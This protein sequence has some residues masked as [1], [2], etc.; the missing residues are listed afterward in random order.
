MR[1]RGLPWLGSVV[2]L[3]LI[4]LYAT[5]I[6]PR[7]ESA[8]PIY[9]AIIW[10]YHQPWYYSP[11]ESY[12]VLPWVRM[13]GVGNYYKMGYI[14]SKYPDVKVTFTFS[15]SLLVQLL[16]YLKG[17]M[18]SY[19]IL[20][21]KAANGTQLSAEDVYNMIKIPGGF[22]DI[23]WNRIVNV[24]PR[25]SQLRSAAQNA[26]ATCSAQPLSEEEFVKCVANAFTFGNYTSQSVI[27]LA[28]LFNLFWIDPQVAREQYPRVYELMQRALNSSYP[29]FT[30]DDLRYVLEVQRDIL[31]K[32]IPLYRDLAAKGQAE[33][34]PVP[35]SHPL[36]PI[37]VDFGWTDDLGVQVARSLEL[38]KEH[39]NYTPRGVWPAEQAVNDQVLEA[40][41]GAGLE[42]AVTDQ[43]LLQATGVNAQDINNL[44][45]PW[46]ANYS[47]RAFYVFFRNTDLSNAISFQ[48]SGMPTSSA[49]DDL[50]SRIRAMAASARGPRL[51]VIALDGENPWENYV[52]FGD[53]FLNAL[54]QRLEE[55]QRQG[56]VFTIT[57]SEFLEKFP[58]EAKQLQPKLYEYL[59][60]AGK[61]ISNIPLDSWGDGY[62]ELPRRTVRAYMPEGSWASG[63]IQ[64]WI[65]SRQDNVAWMWMAKARQDVLKALG[66]SSLTEA[67]RLNPTAVE[68]LLRA[69]ASDWWYWYG[70]EMGSPRTFD[71]IFKAFLRQAY[72]AAGLTPPD[73][74]SATFY[75]D[76]QPIGWMNSAVPMPVEQM[77]APD[78]LESLVAQGR[79]LK[80]PVGPSPVTYAYVAVS[81]SSAYFYFLVAP[82]SQGITLAIY[83]ASPKTDLSPYH[84]GYNVFPP[85]YTADLGIALV[86]QVLL[87]FGAQAAD[88][89]VALGNGEWRHVGSA[90]ASNY[91][92]P[93]GTLA[94]VEVPWSLLNFSGGNRV[95]F[96]LAV[97]VN[98]TL[99]ES[100]TKLGN[101]WLV[102]VPMGVAGGRVIFDMKDP[103][104]DDDG[105]GGYQYPK[106]PVFVKGVFDMTEFKVLDAGDRLVFYTY[107]VTLG[108]NPWGGPNGW[109]MQ[110]VHIY[111]HTTLPGGNTTT[112]GLNV[113]VDPA[114]AWHFA[115]LLAPGWG[116]DPVPGGQKSALYYSNGTVIV[117]DTNGFRVYADQASNA[118][119]AEVPKALLP[120]VADVDKWIF[121][122]AVT[123]YDGFSPTKVRAFGIEA[124]QWVCGAPKYA[125]AILKGVL[126]YVLDVLAPTAEDQYAMLNSFDA[127]AGKLAVIRGYGPS[128]LQAT[129]PTTTTPVTTSPPAVTTTS[130]TTT[131]PYTTSPASTTSLTTTSPM[132]VTTSTP[133]RTSSATTQAPAGVPWHVYVLGIALAIVIIAGAA[134]ALR[135]RRS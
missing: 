46:Y 95:Y 110:Y 117:Q 60:L 99:V 4:A 133:Q 29:G 23:N 27:D 55:L 108:G 98:G 77:P 86:Y 38:F 103:V 123:S 116:T 31:S 132:A 72:R 66:A 26:F 134:I 39:F 24:V 107:F 67:L 112:F 13:H 68:Y 62:N 36:A 63:S 81:Y 50:V 73:Y 100:A 43:L 35:Y 97:Y 34:I 20:A 52:N 93:N 33:L 118:I 84:P 14:L 111:V 5:S 69:E 120:D 106:A 85:N 115:L 109:S 2:V 10:H 30:R 41:A 49:V 80:V 19:Q 94:A 125:Q 135:A 21:W 101:V 32:I 54:Y 102:Q 76:G 91:K 15:G 6:V 53:D 113:E 9:V 122:V 79:A 59:D 128:T 48:Y 7:G 11:D 121:V 56:L 28:T 90:A 18:D 25:Y 17:K 130:P 83:F 65:G 40:F 8:Q 92:V 114:Q 126:P 88:V 47:G 57:P 1:A 78:A 124:E 70:G 3:V 75:P 37:I 45:V 127:S 119:V 12:F 51:V 96:T 131:S 89:Y 16:D 64:T 104:G 87:G 61:D 44:G 71:P 74:L 105:A 22:F 58:G 42:W 82:E 129:S